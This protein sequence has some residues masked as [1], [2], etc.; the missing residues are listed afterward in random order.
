MNH[1]LLKIEKKSYK[2]LNILKKKNYTWDDVFSLL[3][4]KS[5]SSQNYLIKK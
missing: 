5:V 2:R 3:V 1:K 4:L